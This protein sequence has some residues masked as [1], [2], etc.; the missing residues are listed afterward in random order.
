MIFTVHTCMYPYSGISCRACIQP[1][2][3]VMVRVEASHLTHLE[4][5]QVLG[6][7]G[8]NPQLCKPAR[9]LS[10]RKCFD[11]TSTNY[12]SDTYAQKVGKLLS[13]IVK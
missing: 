1:C 4:A 5:W 13:D 3:Y 9:G 7:P 6:H 8:H 12:I 10:C 11:T 2:D